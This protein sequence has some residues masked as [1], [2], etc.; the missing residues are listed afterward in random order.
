MQGVAVEQVGEL[1]DTREPARAT[2]RIW[3]VR[4]PVQMSCEA[5][6]PGL[7][8]SFVD[9]LE[10]RPDRPVGQPRVCVGLDAGHRR[11][12]VADQPARRRELDVGAHAV[13]APGRRAEATRHSLGEPALHAARR[14]GDD[15]GGEGVGEGV[16]QKGAKR[17]DQAVCPFSS[18]DVEHE[19]SSLGQALG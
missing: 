2:S 8:E 10:Q 6:Q 5:R 3:L 9:D 12:G 19:W 4:S 14:D 15:L 1:P 18:V 16:E 7:G 11:D 17:V 13:E